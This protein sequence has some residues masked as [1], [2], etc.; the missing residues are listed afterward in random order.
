MY[1]YKCGARV[2]CGGNGSWLS[3]YQKAWDAPIENLSCER[4]LG[5]IHNTFAVAIS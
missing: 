3:Q 5:N 2:Y 1:Q 4:E